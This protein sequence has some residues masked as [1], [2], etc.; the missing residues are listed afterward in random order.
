MKPNT[1]Y[2]TCDGGLVV[3][4]DEVTSGWYQYKEWDEEARRWSEPKI[5]KG[6]PS[7]ATDPWGKCHVSPERSRVSIQSGPGIVVT[8]YEY[9]SEGKRGAK[10]VTRVEK[11]RD[12]PGTWKEYLTLHGEDIRLWFAKRDARDLA[13]R[14]A[15]ALAVALPEVTPALGVTSS[16]GRG[17]VN[18]SASFRPVENSSGRVIDYEPALTL[19][20]RG[21]AAGAVIERLLP[22]LNLDEA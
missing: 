17:D 10:G 13:Q 4:G 16:F 7:E 1:E 11:P 19:T 22:D 5:G 12:I 15:A 18:V 14:Q 21:I 2:A 8:Q 9:D 20:F 3:T 6:H